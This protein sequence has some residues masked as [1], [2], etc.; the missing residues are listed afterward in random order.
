MLSRRLLS[1][2]SGVLLFGAVVSAC[3]SSSDRPGFDDDKE[4][5]AGPGIGASSG[6]GLGGD[7]GDTLSG[8]TVELSGTTFAP[9][10]E[11]PLAGVLVYWATEEPEAIPQGVYCDKCV[12]LPE[13]RSVFSSVD[14]TFKLSI[15]SERDLYL[16]VQKGQFRRVRKIRVTEG[17][18][19]LDEEF[20]T[21]PGRMKRDN[22]DTIPMIA[23]MTEPDST[24]YDMIQTALDGLGIEEWDNFDDDRSKLDD[25]DDY[26]IMMF[27]CGSGA[28]SGNES[29][30][31][32]DYVAK[33]GKIYASDYAHAWADKVFPEF[34]TQAM[35]TYTPARAPAGTIEDEGMA[36]WLAAIGDDP[37]DVTFEGV[38][39]QFNGVQ[40]AEVPTPENDGNVMSVE[41]K[42]WTRVSDNG[43]GSGEASVSF[44][45]GCGR[46]ISS[47]FHVH[48]E[49]SNNLMTQ[50]KALLYMLLEVSS[51]VTP[52]PDIR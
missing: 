7:G 25:L 26:N 18:S 27:P 13:G 45:Y 6:N 47:I 11:L 39:S 10:G 17:D 31:V 4:G 2:A 36:E 46:G 1:V 48:G 14:G 52:G 29:E 15:P 23:V 44:N 32:R 20:T 24:T 3:S 5:G 19:T 21:L 34:Y 50:E 22:G 49:D 43:Y 40:A 37:Q 38:W 42:V 41:P 9:N 30:K 33:G 51:C 35:G 16:V 12:E 28:P 8:P